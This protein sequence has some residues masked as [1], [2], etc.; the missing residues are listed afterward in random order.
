MDRIKGRA[1]DIEKF[2]KQQTQGDGIVTLADKQALQN[3]L[4]VLKDELN[5]YL[6]KEYGVAPNK[7]FDYQKWLNSHKPF[8]WFIAFYGILKKG[9]FDVIIGNPP[10]LE[11]N[12]VDYAPNT[13]LSS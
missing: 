5:E 13:N 8:H 9:G 6:A 7:Q 4:Q 12:E 10:Y 2:R 1:E 11:L 3:K